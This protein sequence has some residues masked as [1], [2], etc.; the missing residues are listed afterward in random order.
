MSIN[1]ELV[2]KQ[3]NYTLNKNDFYKKNKK[4]SYQ[5]LSLEVISGLISFIPFFIAYYQ[6]NS[7]SLISFMIGF[8]IYAF[9]AGVS[10]HGSETKDHYESYRG[11][12]I[13]SLLIP[14]NGF[15]YY[16]YNLIL[17]KNFQMKNINCITYSKF[18]RDKNFLFYN[19]EAEI[20]YLIQENK[21]SDA[22][23]YWNEIINKSNDL[24]MKEYAVNN[25]KEIDHIINNKNL[26]IE[27]FNKNKIDINK[28]VKH[29]NIKIKENKIKKIEIINL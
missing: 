6:E 9:G 3:V 24:N 20:E 13:P 11:K 15:F 25:I 10:F 27:N 4:F 18:I 14:I 5:I 19:Q 8:I 7:T 23:Y 29:H 28:I 1:Q 12:F 21:A 16:F 2:D 22:I 17:I 26:R